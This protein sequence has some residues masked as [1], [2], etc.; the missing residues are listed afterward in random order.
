MACRRQVAGLVPTVV[1]LSGCAAP[2]RCWHGRCCAASPRWLARWGR[3]CGPFLLMLRVAGVFELAPLPGGAATSTPV[4]AGHGEGWGGVRYLPASPGTATR[5]YHQQHEALQREAVELAL[6]PMRAS[7][8][9]AAHLLLALAMLHRSSAPRAADVWLLHSDERLSTLPPEGGPPSGPL[10]VHLEGAQAEHLAFQ[11]AL[12]PTSSLFNVSVVGP[13]LQ[14]QGS[15]AVIE[16]DSP[17]RRVE[18]VNVTGEGARD[19]LWS[20]PL[21]LLRP[22]DTFEPGAVGGVWITLAIPTGATPGNYS[23]VLKLSADGAAA[24]PGERVHLGT[25]KVHLRVYGFGV[26]NRSL[27]TDAKLSDTWVRK[28]AKREPDGGNITAVMLRYYRDLADH[29]VTM[30]G[31]GGVSIYP[32]IAATF[33]QS[34][35]SVEL[36]TESFDAMAQELEEM[37]ITTIHFPL[38]SVCS[39]TRSTSLL[40]FLRLNEAAAQAASRSPTY[41]RRYRRSS[42]RTRRGHC[43]YE[44]TAAQRR[45]RSSTAQHHPTSFRC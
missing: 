7:A 14:A 34:F 37:G 12:H 9:G 5:H 16:L 35:S 6:H 26:G 39:C 42:H 44:R 40:S 22:A 20:D 33:S 27:H 23:S 10:D 32:P 25:V 36:E 21:P 38:P 31:W 11:I 29:R 28:Y 3:P 1:C 19:G 13:A 2:T 41:G 8:A 4:G 30:A 24:T 15:G 17:I 45:C 18:F 43:R